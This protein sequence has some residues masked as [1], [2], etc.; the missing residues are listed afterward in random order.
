MRYRLQTMIPWRRI[1]RTTRS[2][3]SEESARGRTPTPRPFLSQHATSACSTQVSPEHPRRKASRKQP[4]CPG[5][6]ENRCS[7][8]K[9]Q[10][11]P[12]LSAALPDRPPSCCQPAGS[13]TVPPR[14][15]PTPGPR[16]PPRPPPPPAPRCSPSY[17]STTPFSLF[18]LFLVCPRGTAQPLR[19]PRA[20]SARIAR[21]LSAFVRPPLQHPASSPFCCSGS[22]SSSWSSSSW[23]SALA[24]APPRRT[25]PVRAPRRKRS[26][27]T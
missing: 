18:R 15:V 3:G 21:G 16:C 23:L 9:A 10:Q 4:S 11:L 5:D 8:V 22:C 19:L 26:P 20:K 7:D 14:I 13:A 6:V 12:R 1:I 25:R 2:S 17:L 24:P 27:R